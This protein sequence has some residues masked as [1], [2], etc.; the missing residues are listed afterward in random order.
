MNIISNI[1]NAPII[2]PI[3]KHEDRKANDVHVAPVPNGEVLPDGD[4]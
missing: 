1:M 2:H 4:E 3:P